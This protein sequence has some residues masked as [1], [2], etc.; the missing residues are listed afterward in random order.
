[1]DKSFSSDPS[2]HA[3]TLGAK[4]GAGVSS[5]LAAEVREQTPQVRGHDT[6]TVDHQHQELTEEHGSVSQKI[7]TLW[8]L[9][10][11]TI[12]AGVGTGVGVGVVVGAGVGVGVVVGAGVGGGA[13]GGAG[14]GAGVGESTGSVHNPHVAGH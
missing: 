11:T 8:S 10:V 9:H 7:C 4:V 6:L 13:V 12:G 3:P 1:M 14:V 2:S 5:D